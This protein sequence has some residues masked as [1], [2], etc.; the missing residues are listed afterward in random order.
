[1]FKIK[2]TKGRNMYIFADSYDSAQKTTVLKLPE[3]C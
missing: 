2:P 3:S 1:M